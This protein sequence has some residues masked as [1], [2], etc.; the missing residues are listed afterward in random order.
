[1]LC[2]GALWL[3]MMT[4]SMSAIAASTSARG[5]C[6]AAIVPSSA[7]AAAAASTMKRPRAA[8]SVIRA[9]MSI[10]PAAKSAT[11]SP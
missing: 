4:P 5:A 2:V 7:P 9:S 8:E 10:A 1:M 6:T 11:N 3:A